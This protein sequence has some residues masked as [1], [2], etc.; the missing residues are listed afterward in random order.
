MNL[1]QRRTLQAVEN[2][3]WLFVLLGWRGRNAR[4]EQLDDEITEARS[5]ITWYKSELS[6]LQDLVLQKEAEMAALRQTVAE[7]A[8]QLRVKEELL[9]SFDSFSAMFKAKRQ[10]AV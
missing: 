3:K 6:K 7:Q 10:Q 1:L 5:D 4:I 2:A 8:E 9:Q